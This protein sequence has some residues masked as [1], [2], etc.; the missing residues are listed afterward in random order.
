[1]ASFAFKFITTA[2]ITTKCSNFINEVTINSTFKLCIS[3][4]LF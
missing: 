3:F 4:F 2:I 1:M